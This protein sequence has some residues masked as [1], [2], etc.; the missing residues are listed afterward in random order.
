VGTLEQTRT[1][2]PRHSLFNGGLGAALFASDCLDARPRFPIL[3][4]WLGRRAGHEP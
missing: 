2:P 4:D 3:D 1:L